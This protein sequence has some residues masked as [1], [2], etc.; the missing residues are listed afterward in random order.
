MKLL[1]AGRW[2]PLKPLPVF[3]Y[4]TDEYRAA[5][6]FDKMRGEWVCRKT[7]FPSNKIQELRGGLTE[8]TMA[9]PRGQ[10][11]VFVE[12]GA[13]EQ[14]EQE[15]EKDASRRLQAIRE[16]REKYE[17]GILYYGLQDYLSKSQRDEIDDRI[18]L[19]LTARQLQFTA[20]NVAYVFD[21]LLKAGGK[22]AMLIEIAQRNKTEHGADIPAKAEAAG[23]DAEPQIACEKPAPEFEGLTAVPVER[24]IPETIEVFP[25]EPTESIFSESGR[26]SWR[27]LIAHTSSQASKIEAR[28]TLEANS[29]WL[30]EDLQ[31]EVQHHARVADFGR[32]DRA[33]RVES[34]EDRIE[35]ARSRLGVLEISGF[36]VAA[37]VFLLA[38]IGLAVGL[39]VGRGLFGERLQETQKSIPAVDATPPELVNRSDGT[40]SQTSTA[41]AA[42][43]FVAPAVIPPAPATTGLGSESPAA[44]TLN[45]RPED[46]AIRV[47]PIGPSPAMT[48][49]SSP[50]SDNREAKPE[51]Q[52]S[53]IARNAPPSANSQLAFSPK[54][55]GPIS[56]APANPAPRR[57]TIAT[58]TV[59]HLSSPSTMLVTGPGD[60]SRPF[61]L[62][63][64]EKPIAASSS[65]AMTSQLSVLVSPE[66]GAAAAHTPARLQAGQLVSFIWPRYP[67]PGERHGSSETVKVRATIGEL[68]QVLDVKHV[69]GSTSLLPAAMSAIRQWRYEPTLLNRRPVQAQQDVT[70]EFRGPQ[71]LAPVPTQRPAHN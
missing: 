9:L 60:G 32:Q 27:E 46:S 61:R 34:S 59:P 66:G 7:S 43:T 10:A 65:F 51:H 3:K 47:E 55:V 49:R 57:V 63:L 2:P 39:A 45:A 15:L 42:N 68:G 52:G 13:A 67:R 11:E 54:A 17:S 50:N 58:R 24:L 6:D 26:P 29:P 62:M 69:S 30:V 38:V 40:T 37:V 22:V 8:I 35:N 53:L 56:G 23:P 33:G 25:E 18:R 20:K 48:N 16:W 70:V 14:P 31:E 28:E 19:T 5:I 21:A 44:Q 64:P 4:E 1:V 12:C 41:P 71:H 36:H